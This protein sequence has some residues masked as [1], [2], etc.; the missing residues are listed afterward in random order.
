MHPLGVRCGAIAEWEP[1]GPSTAPAIAIAAGN[2]AT[3]KAPTLALGGTQVGSRR[4]GRSACR[5]WWLAR[6]LRCSISSGGGF[7]D[8]MT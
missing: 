2:P 5:C 8:S 4:N 7:L 3:A 1:H 6:F